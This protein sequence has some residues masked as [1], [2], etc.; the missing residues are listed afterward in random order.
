MRRLETFDWWPELLTLKDTLSLRELAE[1]F[2][3]TPG[4]IS[5]ALKRTGTTRRAAAPGPKPGARHDDDLPPEPGDEPTRPINA[6]DRPGS[7]DR[8]LLAHRDLLGTMP[9]AEVARR[10]GVSVRTVAAFRARHR[11]PPYT[12]PRRRADGR[13]SRID[14]W[15]GSSATVQDR[16]FGED[17]GGG[18]NAVRGWRP[19]AGIAAAAAEATRIVAGRAHAWQVTLHDGGET[20]TRIVLAGT[21]LEAANAAASSVG[22]GVEVVGVCWVGELLDERVSRA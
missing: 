4:A 9:D 2:Q 19:N 1:R 22:D 13:P 8:Q 15:A 3:V 18:I 7:K 14:G 12:G 5:A 10:A 21:L 6:A 16:M 11:I 20:S 17:T